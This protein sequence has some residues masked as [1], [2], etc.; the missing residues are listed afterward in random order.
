[1][2]CSYCRQEKSERYLEPTFCGHQCK[3]GCDIPDWL[4]FVEIEGHTPRY[5]I[6]HRGLA[7]LVTP[8]YTIPMNDLAV[9][10]EQASAFG[11]HYKLPRDIESAK[12]MIDDMMDNDTLMQDVVNEANESLERI[13]S[14]IEK[15]KKKESEILGMVDEVV[16]F[17][18]LL[19]Q[20][21]TYIPWH[22]EDKE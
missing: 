12:R 2:K 13:A 10:F 15:L 19:K 17:H 9:Y 21:E 22:K 1:M 7:F 6:V 3:G 20:G 4:Q 8:R 16:R 5:R 14:K 18:G 11:V